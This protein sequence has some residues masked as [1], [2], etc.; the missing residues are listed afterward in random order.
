MSV[1]KNRKKESHKS[2]CQCATCKAKRGEYVGEPATF[3]NKKQTEKTKKKISEKLK[4]LYKNRLKI[5]WNENLT[6][7]TDDRVRKQAKKMKGNKNSYVNGESKFPYAPCW[8]DQL[9]E[10]IRKR[11]N[12]TC[13]LCGK[14]QEEQLKE[15]GYKLSVHHIDYHK[16][17]CDEDK[18]ITL[19]QGCNIK[20]NIDKLGYARFFLTYLEVKREGFCSF[21]KYL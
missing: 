4:W 6:K 7:E 19:C 1:C 9:K 18:L 13:Q 2:N 14:T 12:Y 11:D 10:K 20:V 21:F 8:N 3:Y 17:H 16:F 15:I 5:V